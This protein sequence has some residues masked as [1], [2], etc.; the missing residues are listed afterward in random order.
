M[1]KDGLLNFIKEPATNTIKVCVL[2]ED[3]FFWIYNY[4][5]AVRVTPSQFREQ[6]VPSKYKK[7][8]KSFQ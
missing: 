5:K 6:Q 1:K 4:F 2:K 3:R 7:Y 8:R